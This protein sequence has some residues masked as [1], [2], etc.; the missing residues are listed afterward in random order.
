MVIQESGLNISHNE[1][2]RKLKFKKAWYIK[3]AKYIRSNGADINELSYLEKNRSKKYKKIKDN[4][5]NDKIGIELNGDKTPLAAIT[6]ININLDD[7]RTNFVL[8]T[9][10][11][12]NFTN[13]DLIEYEVSE[14]GIYLYI[15]RFILLY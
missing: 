4:G 13:N 6:K 10:P 5:S 8:Q 14:K 1:L 11:I 3:Y 15:F 12:I 2:L 9:K 7:N